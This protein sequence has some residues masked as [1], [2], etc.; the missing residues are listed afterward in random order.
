MLHRM[1]PARVG[2]IRDKVK[3][4]ILV[5]ATGEEAGSVPL[6]RR[7]KAL[8]GMSALDV[9]CGG[10]LLS[11]NLARLGAQTTAI[12]AS[13]PNIEVARMHAQFDQGLQGK[14]T[15]RHTSTDDLVQEKPKFDLVCSM[16]VL[17]HVDNPS[18][19]LHTCAELV[20]PGGHLFLSTIARTPLA[21][22]TNVVLAE[23]F[24]GIVSKGTHTYSKFVKP[25]ELVDFFAKDVPWIT[26]LYD[27]VPTRAEAEVRSMQFNPFTGMWNVLPRGDD[28]LP[29]TERNYLFWVRRPL[30]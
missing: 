19:F 6:S 1:N 4:T 25:S 26:R 8:S 15:Y 3:E 7:R 14:L 11:E 5:E 18:H 21:Y 29:G 12:D 27:G 2:F 28:V 23:N 30:A 22:F 24:L 17:E 16:E 13:S 9:G 20:K 10:G